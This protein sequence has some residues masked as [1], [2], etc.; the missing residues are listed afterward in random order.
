[1]N[2]STT[3]P[4]L[5]RNRSFNLLWSSQFLSGLG[6]N[7]SGI[8]FPLLVLAI[9]GSAISAGVVGTA[10]AAVRFA[11]RIPAGVLVDRVNRK[12]VMLSC[13]A[14]RLLAYGGLALIVVSGH[15]NLIV[16]IVF[17]V[18]DAVG[19]TVFET[20]EMAALR[21][22]VS[23]EQ[24]PSAHARNEARDQAAALVGP[25]VGGLLF[26]AARALPFVADAVSYALSFIGAA[27]IR[28][29]F[30]EERTEESS[31]AVSDMRDGLRFC[32]CQPF[33]RA[34]IILAPP[35]NLAVNGLIFAGIIIL[36]KD[37]LTPGLVGLFETILAVGGLLGAVAAGPVQKLM[38]MRALILGATW[39]AT[40]LIAVGSFLT[41]SLLLA[42]PLAL[43][44]F[45]FP[46]ANAALF[47]YLAA[48]TPDALQGRVISVLLA[49]ATSMA[50][51]APLLAG[52]LYESF[53]AQGTVL[54]FTVA[55]AI[56]AVVATRS[57]VIR[58][59][60]GKPGQEAARAAVAGTG[61]APA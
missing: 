31:S 34:T 20:A 37:G 11:L 57:A 38:S 3:P 5:W 61:T 17:A 59:M 51:F 23:V 54:G 19:G 26:S 40:A 6:T 15:E 7:I 4:N 36:R 33:V 60:S 8:A 1:V 2:E 25:P 56:S 58:S 27:L 12:I 55:T 53:G 50:S 41:G 42:V 24:V 10:A 44:L 21:N 47:G 49:A 30:Q 22:V 45:I 18:V 43:A 9:T 39:I 16:I 14:V 46:A 48:V 32:W 35:L 52:V 13:D 29:P 28:E